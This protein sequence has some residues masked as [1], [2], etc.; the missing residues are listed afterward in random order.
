MGARTKGRTD[1]ED[2]VAFPGGGLWLQ[3]LDRHT[4][5]ELKAWCREFGLTDSGSRTKVIERLRAYIEVEFPDVD[6]EMLPDEEVLG[7]GIDEMHAL[8]ERYGFESEGTKDQLASWLLWYFDDVR[9]DT[10]PIDAQTREELEAMPVE[11]LK[12]LCG[13]WNVSRQGQRGRLVARVLGA[14]RAREAGAPWPPHGKMHHIIEPP[15][16]VVVP[17]G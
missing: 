10:G 3:D 13:M 15:P 7:L 1:D 9:R 11:Q 16:N 12:D 6:I 14:Q 2:I 4:T 17:E 8:L 5:E